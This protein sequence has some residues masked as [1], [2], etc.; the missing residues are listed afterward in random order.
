MGLTRKL[1]LLLLKLSQFTRKSVSIGQVNREAAAAVSQQAG[2][3]PSAGLE[4]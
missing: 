3:H 2:K 1:L 4:V